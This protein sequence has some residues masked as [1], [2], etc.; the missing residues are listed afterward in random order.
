MYAYELKTTLFEDVKPD[1]KILKPGPGYDLQLISLQNWINDNIDPKDLKTA[2]ITWLMDQKRTHEAQ[3]IKNF[4][5][6]QTRTPGM[7]A[8]MLLQGSKLSDRTMQF[9]NKKIDEILVKYGNTDENEVDDEPTEMTKSQ[10]D[11]DQYQQLQAIL[12]Q[13]VRS[14]IPNW[15]K[16]TD[17]VKSMKPSPKAIKE[18]I[19]DLRDVAAYAKSTGNRDQIKKLNQIAV[20]LKGLGA[21]KMAMSTNRKVKIKQDDGSIDIRASKAATKAIG[22]IKYLPYSSKYNITSIKPEKVIGAKAVL[23]FDEDSRLLNLFVANSS[24][25]LNF[26]KSKLQGWSP[27]AGSVTRR[28]RKPERDLP[29]MLTGNLSKIQKIMNADLKGAKGIPRPTLKPTTVIL[30]AY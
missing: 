1:F 7:Y 13:Y 25:G 29:K 27:E 24:T 16:I 9:L 21:T 11:M 8:Y 10:K 23:T 30:K 26:K 2:L 19:K 3:Q 17:L 14:G 22:E 6:W 20:L 5:D 18:V 12:K 15:D 28:L 4:K